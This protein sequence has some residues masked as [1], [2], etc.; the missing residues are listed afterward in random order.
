MKYFQL[1]L[2][3]R[4]NPAP[5]IRGWSQKYDTRFI[6]AKSSHKLPSR[7]LLFVEPDENLVFPDVLSFPF[8]LVTVKVL[9]AIKLYQPT[10]VSKQ[11][12]L[13]DGKNSKSETYFLPILNSVD[14][15]HPDTVWKSDKKHFKA[16]ILD[17]SNLGK[18]VIF[19]PAGAS[20]S[21]AIINLDLAESIL[22][23]DAKGIGLTPVEIK[24]PN[25]E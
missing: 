16:L 13:L 6:S 2:N 11:I 4:Y 24:N 10:M 23:R 1:T 9:N 7:D 17:K 19:R 21:I 5:Y 25:K 15:V 18:D 22:R 12:I 20:H 8:F 14:C 3:P